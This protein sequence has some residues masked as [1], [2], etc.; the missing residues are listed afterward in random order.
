MLSPDHIG[1]AQ[2]RFNNGFKVAEVNVDVGLVSLAVLFVDD[3]QLL[4]SAEGSR[5]CCR[6]QG[7]ALGLLDA[8]VQQEAAT[9]MFDRPV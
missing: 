3:V 9:H 1:G 7:V 4:G 2:Y 8:G 6:V 5:L